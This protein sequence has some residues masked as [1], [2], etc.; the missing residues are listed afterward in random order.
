MLGQRVSIYALDYENDTPLHM[1]AARG[2]THM[3]EFLLQNG[4]NINAVNLYGDSP[5]QKAIDLHREDTASVLRSAGAQAIRGTPEQRDKAS[6]T[7][8]RQAI[9][10]QNGR[11]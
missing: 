10:K 6:E 3:V 1:A 11:Y 7:I 9:E 4:A 2:Q 8:V 5:L